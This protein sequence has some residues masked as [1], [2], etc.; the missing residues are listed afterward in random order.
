MIQRGR[1]IA[2]GRSPRLTGYQPYCE[3]GAPAHEATGLIVEALAGVAGSR[4]GN[5]MSTRLVL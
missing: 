1:R 5:G 4:A 3:L 2:A